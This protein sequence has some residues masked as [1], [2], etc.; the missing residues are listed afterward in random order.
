MQITFFPIFLSFQVIPLSPCHLFLSN[1][2]RLLFFPC[3][4]LY[5]SLIKKNKFLIEIFKKSGSFKTKAGKKENAQPQTRGG[6][7][8]EKAA[9]LKSCGVLT[10]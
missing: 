3:F 9:I 8:K 1:V 10:I 7:L 5:C 6:L 4:P 2:F